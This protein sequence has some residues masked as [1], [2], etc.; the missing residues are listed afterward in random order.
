[1]RRAGAAGADE[2]VQAP[3]A[4]ARPARRPRRPLAQLAPAQRV[5]AAPW[6]LAHSAPFVPGTNTSSSLFGAP[7]FVTTLMPVAKLVPGTNLGD[8]VYWGY[9]ASVRW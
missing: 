7:E 1:M 3:A 4:S 6:C 9:E 5:M 2:A 8:P